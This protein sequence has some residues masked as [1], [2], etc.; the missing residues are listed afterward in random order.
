M[1][2]ALAWPLQQAVYA[3]LQAD[4]AIA[5]LVEDRIYDAAPHAERTD[6][7]LADYITLGDETVRAWDTADGQGS[8]HDFAVTVHSGGQGYAQ[9]KALAG[10]ICD[11]LVDAD[12]ALSRGRLIGLRFLQAQAQRGKGAERRR[13]ALRF[14]AIIEDTGV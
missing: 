6:A 10:V 4:P 13:I 12:L 1:T 8:S 5:A 14:R 7:P 3:A 9:S 11:V 2:Y